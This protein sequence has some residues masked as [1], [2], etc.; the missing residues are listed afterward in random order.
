MDNDSKTSDKII[1]TDTK[2][3][4]SSAFDL[5]PIKHIS[6]TL[7]ETDRVQKLQTA[8]LVLG[9]AGGSCLV[10]PGN[11]I[12]TPQDER[13]PYYSK[14]E[15][16]KMRKAPQGELCPIEANYIATRFTDWAKELN[17]TVDQLTETERCFVS[18]LTWIDT[19]AL[20][21]NS[22]VSEAEASRLTQL[23]PKETHPET[24]EILS[25]QRVVHANMARLDM[26]VTQRRML[27]K[28]WM[29]TPEQKAKQAKWEGRTVGNDISKKQSATADK[30]RDLGMTIV[31][32]EEKEEE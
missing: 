9:P 23:D 20:R 5:L 6:L 21:C 12:N 28:D 29:L 26:L 7:E 13:C 15:L 8:L 30:L 32:Q 27:L 31:N 25:W 17:R 14:C 4:T 24:G 1:T 18:D 2:A 3:L 22:I 19:Q 10:C 11:Q 16:L